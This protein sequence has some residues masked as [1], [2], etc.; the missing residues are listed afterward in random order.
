[1]DVNGLGRSS[2]SLARFCSTGSSLLEADLHGA[3]IANEE[4]AEALDVDGCSAG[5]LLCFTLLISACQDL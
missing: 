2:S 1:M 5:L 3:L 4:V